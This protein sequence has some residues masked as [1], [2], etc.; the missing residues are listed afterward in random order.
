VIQNE[1][2]AVAYHSFPGAKLALLGAKWWPEN[3]KAEYESP[4]MKGA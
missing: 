2:L 1:N 3:R 4:E